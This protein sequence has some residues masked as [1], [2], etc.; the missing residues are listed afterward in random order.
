MNDPGIQSDE[1]VSVVYAPAD[2]SERERVTG[3]ATDVRTGVFT[4][5]SDSGDP[6]LLVQFATE[7]VYRR[8]TGGGF[9]REGRLLGVQPAKSA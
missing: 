3:T 1:Y 8:T 9:V 7:D 4:L 6:T 2:G 5:D